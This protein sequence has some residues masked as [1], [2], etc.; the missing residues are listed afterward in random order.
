MFFQESEIMNQL[1]KVKVLLPVKEELIRR[2]MEHKL[3]MEI[4]SF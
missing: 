2:E 3:L 4:S 1:V